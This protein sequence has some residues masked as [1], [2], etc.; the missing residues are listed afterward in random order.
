MRKLIAIPQAF[1]PLMR[2][3]QMIQDLYSKQFTRFNQL[4]CD[5]DVLPTW[6]QVTGWVIVTENNRY[7]VSQYGTFNHL[8]WHDDG[9]GN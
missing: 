6:S 4:F 8:P 2:D 5:A 1:K 7:R 3:D 9:C